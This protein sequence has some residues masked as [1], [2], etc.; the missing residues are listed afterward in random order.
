MIRSYG[1]IYNLG[2]KYLEHLLDEEV[3]IEE[4]IDGSQFSFQAHGDKLVF[5]SSGRELHYPVTD[6]LFASAVDYITSIKHCLTL[7]WIY[8][9]EVLHQPKHNTIC[10]NRIPL[11][12]IILF[13]VD[14]G[15]QCYV[16]YDEKVRIANELDLE[17]VPKLARQSVKDIETLKSFLDKE[18]ILGGS[19][20]EGIV[21][22]NYDR[23]GKDGKALMGKWVSEA[24]KEKHGTEW[25]NKSAASKDIIQQLIDTYKHENRWLKAIQHF[26]E[27]GKLEGIPE[28]IGPLIKEIQDDVQKECG[29]EIKEMIFKKIWPKVMRGITSGFPEFY[30]TKLAK[31][32]FTGETK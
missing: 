17:V 22:K 4:K 25:K 9:G 16:D 8:R 6:K 21:I 14:K 27:Q 19:K 26:K 1:K 13:D 28:E 11:H 15:D 10:Y 18:S 2:H 23:F 7:G 32:Q 24:F 29:D 31:K 3:L 30:K 12:N 5:R 20:I